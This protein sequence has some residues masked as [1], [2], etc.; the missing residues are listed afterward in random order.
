[1]FELH[2]KLMKPNLIFICIFFILIN[3]A[4]LSAQSNIGQAIE[5]QDPWIRSPAPFAQTLAG[6]MNIKNHL[7]R[8]VS[9]VGVRSDNFDEVMLH[10]SINKNG[11]HSMRHAEKIIIPPNG[12]IIFQPG[13]YHI[14]F[15]GFH[16][17]IIPGKNIPVTLVFNNGVE[18]DVLF[19]VRNAK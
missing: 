17:K 6:F 1:M 9:L 18:K 13:G 16:S 3:P 8:A 19:V 4:V 5:I 14:M 10:Q 11:M 12:N 2:R 7:N 15:I